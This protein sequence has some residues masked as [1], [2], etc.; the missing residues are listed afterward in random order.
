MQFVATVV[1]AVFGGVGGFLAVTQTFGWQAGCEIGATVAVV[2]VVVSVIV[3]FVWPPNT[4]GNSPASGLVIEPPGPRLTGRVCDVGPFAIDA[5]TMREFPLDLAKGERVVGNITET[6]GQDFDWFIVDRSNL[7]AARRGEEFDYRQGNAND[8]AGEI[9]W[10][11]TKDGPWYLLFD[12][13]RKQLPRLIA[14]YL[15]RT[16]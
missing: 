15:E 8:Y 11:A 7:A 6:N 9:K 3:Y 14:I 4:D 5:Y 12:H 10:R 13:S 16:K 2:A 1:A